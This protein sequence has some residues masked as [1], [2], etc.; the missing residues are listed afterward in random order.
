MGKS[1]STEVLFTNQGEG[2]QSRSYLHNSAFMQL[3]AAKCKPR[4]ER[5]VQSLFSENVLPFEVLHVADLGSSASN[6]TTFSVMATVIDTAKCK[7]KEL[8]L[9]M[10]EFQ[11]WFNDLPGSDFNTLF[12][13]LSSFAV[14][15]RYTDVLCLVMGV[16]GS[17]YGRLF[18]KSSLHLVHSFYNVHW[19]SKVPLLRDEAE[20]LLPLNKEKIYISTTSPPAVREAY[21]SQFQD[22]FSTFLKLR[23]QEMV[24]NGRIVLM[25]QGRQ[26]ADPTSKECCYQ[27]EILAKALTEMVSQKVIDEEKLDSF[28]VPYYSPSKE[29]VKEVVDKE[30]SFA[31]ELLETFATELGDKNIWR[32]GKEIA[33]S[34]RS[35]TESVISDHFGIEI[36]DKLYEKVTDILIQDLATQSD[37]EP[38]KNISLVVVLKRM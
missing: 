29:E 16:P 33:N 19:L 11:F 3:M 38:I 10:P 4:L 23:S 17:F 2:Q 25:L 36:I 12:K 35:F 26:S 1:D 27:W 15:E 37:D 18:P 28:D 22:D 5:A 32:S 7:C 14:G 8:G 6:P 20:S 34:L 9:Q 31:T 13:G 30:G 24:P 21:L